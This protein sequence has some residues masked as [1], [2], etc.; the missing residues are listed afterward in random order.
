M[1][2]AEA[3]RTFVT[4]VKDTVR[5]HLQGKGSGALGNLVTKAAYAAY[6]AEDFLPQISPTTAWRT[7]LGLGAVIPTI[8][9]TVPAIV[10]SAPELTP[11]TVETGDFGTITGK[12]GTTAKRIFGEEGDPK[13]GKQK[14]RVMVFPQG[15]NSMQE[16]LPDAQDMVKA[17]FEVNP[18]Q[19][20]TG[21]IV[22]YAQD[23]KNTPLASG[24]CAILGVSQCGT[25]RDKDIINKTID[26]YDKVFHESIWFVNSNIA[27][28]YPILD[29]NKPPSVHSSITFTKELLK[30]QLRPGVAHVIFHS[31]YNLLAEYIKPDLGGN[32]GDMFWNCTRNPEKWKGKPGDP[33]RKYKGCLDDSEAYGTGNPNH[34]E[35][36]NVMSDYVYDAGPLNS[37]W[38]EQIMKPTTL[39]SRYQYPP[40]DATMQ[41]THSLREQ[42]V[43][44]NK[45]EI[46]VIQLNDWKVE[47]GL[48]IPEG[49]RQ[50]AV[51]MTPFNG[52]GP[53]LQ[54]IHGTPLGVHTLVERGWHTLT[55]KFNVN[56]LLP[57]MT[58]TFRVRVSSADYSIGWDD[59]SWETVEVA[60]D[61]EIP[62]S[63]EVLRFRTP[64]VSSEG[65][66][67][68]NPNNEQVTNSTTPEL[69]WQ[70]PDENIFYWEVQ[71]SEDPE[72]KT[73]PD[74][75]TASVY[76]NLI[77][78]RE[79]EKK[80]TWK[81]PAGYPLTPGKKY[82]W[83]V[84]PRIQGDGTPVA[85]SMTKG[86]DVAPNA[87]ADP[88]TQSTKESRIVSG[89]QQD[90]L[91]GYSGEGVRGVIQM[92]STSRFVPESMDQKKLLDRQQSQREIQ[93]IRGLLANIHP[94][95][96]RLTE[97]D[98]REMLRVKREEEK[99]SKRSGNGKGN[100][101]TSHVVTPSIE[102]VQ[103]KITPLPGMYE[104]KG[105]IGP[106]DTDVMQFNG[107][108]QPVISNRPYNPSQPLPLPE[109]ENMVFINTAT[110]FGTTNQ[111]TRKAA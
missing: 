85:W 70:S 91:F 99:K 27:T 102:E 8:D 74:K 75:A 13:K 26:N 71:L 58:Y 54:E 57:D 63:A 66:A 72:F 22:F 5:K 17:L 20:Y 93:H 81:V 29:K 105:V 38:I 24:G 19:N 65:M 61:K 23:P 69:H 11:L 3:R 95:E 43:G 50:V 79:T 36:K 7:G 83:R 9:T 106:S 40:L 10:E 77:H 107:N 96:T 55:P 60:P 92:P 104:T 34:P 111:R 32:V 108:K 90:G 110:V 97:D 47:V 35:G 48:I 103:A 31:W 44:N 4:G 37:W 73:E 30:P 14:L 45:D 98:V 49:T 76:W 62:S 18:M 87:K 84:R 101:A 6:N 42:S 88:V 56:V 52:D 21:D 109:P 86:F 12:D 33:G 53:G 28:D 64:K 59:K 82:Y 67:L 80:D 39:L 94:L 1:N 16:F 25:M 41:G 15:Y 78:G 68:V 2:I 100:I 46:P 51:E 89:T